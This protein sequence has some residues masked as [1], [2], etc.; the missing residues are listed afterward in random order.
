MQVFHSDAQAG[1]APDRYA[2]GRD[3]MPARETPDRVDA[4]LA[5]LRRAGH[6]IE[7]PAAFGM[8]ALRAVHDEGYLEFLRTAHARW[9]A[10]FGAD[11]RGEWCVPLAFP[12]RRMTARPESIV[13]QAGYYLSSTTSPI[14]AGTWAAIAG[15]ADC[16]MAGATALLDGARQ[17]YALCRP[18]GHHAYADVGAGFCYVNNVAVAAHHLAQARGRVAILDIDVHHGNGTQG[19]FWRRDDVHFVSIH[20]DPDGG[21]P[22]FAGRADEVGEGPGAG[23]TRNLPLPIGSRDPV[24][25]DAVRAGLDSVLAYRPSMLLVSLGLDA[26]E[27]DPSAMLAVSTDGFAAAG[28]LIGQAGLPT[29]LVQ[30]GGYAVD[31]LGRNL[32]AF[33]GAFLG[34][35]TGG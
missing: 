24:W 31:D 33:L 14:G 17:A 18:P 2:L 19:I 4:L 6:R 27:R 10:Q 7:A 34:A 32:E 30:E 9:R 23:H 35:R 16:A 11:P 8:A 29:L 1:H 5:T 25:L 20:G 21:Y 28:R 26:Y 3:V 12:N 15:A 22:Y 13:G